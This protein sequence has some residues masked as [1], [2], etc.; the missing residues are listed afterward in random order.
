MAGAVIGTKA[1]IAC[2]VLVNAGAAI[3]H[4][5]RDGAFAHLDV[6]ACIAAA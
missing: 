5:A 1:H 3:S 4:H 6:G 2:G